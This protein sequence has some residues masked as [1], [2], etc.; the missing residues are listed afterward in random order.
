MKRYNHAV[1]FVNKIIQLICVQYYEKSFAA[2]RKLKSARVGNI[3]EMHNDMHL[4]HFMYCKLKGKKEYE[5]IGH[6]SM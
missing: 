4:L 6:K 1:K 5:L 3:L 2:F